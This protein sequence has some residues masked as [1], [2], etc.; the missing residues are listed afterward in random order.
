MINTFFSTGLLDS[1]AALF[2]SVL[3][4]IAFG[5]ALE[6]AGFGSSRRLA[7]IFYFRDMTVLKVMFTAVITA[8][9]GLTCAKAAGWVTTENIYFLPTRYTAQILGGLLFGVGFVVGGW[10]PGTGA[11][12]IAS[13]RIDALVFLA[14][15]VGGS[16]LYNEVFPL[17]APL[18]S[19]DSGILFAYSTLGVSEA[20]FAVGFTAIAVICFW[21]VELL[22]R[23][24]GDPDNLWGSP[25]LIIFSVI[26]LGAAL[27]LL[28]F[29]KQP[30]APAAASQ[31]QTLL[32]NLQTGADHIEPQEL[33][34][35]LLGGDSIV[36]VDIRTPAEFDR[37]HIRSAVNIQPAD[38]PSGLA[39]YKNQGL[40]VLYSNGMTH[41]AQ[42]RDSL[43]RLGFSNVYLLTDGLQGFL[44]RCLKPVSLRPE[45]VP[46]ALAAKINAWR[47]FFLAPEP[48]ADSSSNS[49]AD[50]APLTMPGLADTAWLEG[51]LG[52][53]ALK[54][55]DL[56]SQ[57]DYNGGHIPG[58]L[59][60]SVESLRGCVD[61]LPSSLLPA[62][63]LAEHFSLMGIQPDDT[64]VLVCGDKLQD[65]TL[66]GMA[67]E[68]LGH[69]RYAVLQGGFPKWAFEKR[70]LSTLLPGVKPSVYPAPDRPDAFTV[71]AGAVL[72]AIGKPGTVILDARPADYFSGKKQDEARGGHIPGA[73]NR[74][75]PEDVVQTESS[76]AFKP[77]EELAAAYARL[78]PAKD[79]PV[80]V[81][82]RTGHQAGQ[83]WFVLT[84]LLGYTRVKWYD[85]GWTEWAARP[86]LPRE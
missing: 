1:P 71:G 11:V 10:C 48:P 59:S 18:T 41:P 43:A 65:A 27:S 75:Y 54:I 73:V 13:G 4:G 50:P 84:R 52:S 76:T 16:I 20:A 83:T 23:K 25:F 45:P 2:A 33:A 12:G 56:R 81:H 24:K 79:T 34:D 60:L 42:A 38:L 28:V 19:T 29:T 78:I 55:I 46:G 5:A 40:I 70:P 49:A 63:M 3:I 67:C 21:G 37:F 36:L 17:I 68:R 9:L 22:G 82:C 32:E 85:A 31:E 74:P 57:P 61:G 53:P 39:A 47:A 86:E 72:A 7:G 30:A 62:A 80:I 35:R 77:A 44:N 6:N 14:G 58:S 64:L 51:A 15:I 66:A 69:R 8:M 26:L